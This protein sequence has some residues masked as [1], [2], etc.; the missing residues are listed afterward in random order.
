MLIDRERLLGSD[1]RDT[2]DAR[3][4]LATDYTCAGEAERAIPLYERNL[5][6]TERLFGPNH[7]DTLISR[8]NL[9]AVP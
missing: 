8:Y 7:S 3:N 6:D 2:L 5:N 9:R 1:H 4:S